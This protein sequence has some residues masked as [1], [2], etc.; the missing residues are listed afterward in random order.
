MDLFLRSTNLELE[1]GYSLFYQ[2]M[3]RGYIH[4]LYP[5]LAIV[6]RFQVTTILDIEEKIPFWHSCLR[7]ARGWTVCCLQASTLEWLWNLHQEHAIVKA[8]L[9]RAF[10]IARGRRQARL[11]SDLHFFSRLC[12]HPEMVSRKLYHTLSTATDYLSWI[13]SM[14]FEERIGS[15]LHSIL[16]QFDY[17]RTSTCQKWHHMPHCL[18]WFSQV[19]HH[20]AFVHY[21]FLHIFNNPGSSSDWYFVFTVCDWTS[22]AQL[23]THNNISVE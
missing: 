1:L 4:F 21:V 3:S 12:K 23:Y 17:C 7:F 14:L 9:P 5:C 13:S 11:I 10:M 6:R 18:C 15:G 20:T 22:H 2:H 8:T 19:A 16:S